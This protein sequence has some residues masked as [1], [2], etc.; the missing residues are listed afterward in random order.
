MGI[1][2]WKALLAVLA[3]ALASC[4]SVGKPTTSQVDWAVTLD[5]TC[6]GAKSLHA[7]VINLGLLNDEQKAIEAEFVSVLNVYCD[8]NPRPTDAA[9]AV[10]TLVAAAVPISKLVAE[11]SR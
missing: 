5:R 3:V 2:M 10:A 11:M 4:S 7:V 9:S 8:A 6:V 1:S